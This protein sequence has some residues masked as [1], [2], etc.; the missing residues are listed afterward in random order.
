MDFP[1]YDTK[2]KI[3]LSKTDLK[4]TGEVMIIPVSIFLATL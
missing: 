3:I 1:K 2:T 4:T